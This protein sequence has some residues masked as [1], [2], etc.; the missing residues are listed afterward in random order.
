M[1]PPIVAVGQLGAE[2]GPEE[3]LAEP[4]TDV[5]AAVVPVVGVAGAVVPVAELQPPP[6]AEERSPKVVERRLATTVVARGTLLVIAPTTGWRA[7][8]DR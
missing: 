3:F 8:I 1:E 6:V 4:L 5:E 7:T 2:Q